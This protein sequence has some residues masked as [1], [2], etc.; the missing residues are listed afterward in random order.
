MGNFWFNVFTG[1]VCLFFFFFLLF[2]RFQSRWDAHV[3]LKS[4][5]TLSSLSLFHSFTLSSL[6]AGDEL[7]VEII[8]MLTTMPI[9]I[10]MAKLAPKGIEACVYSFVRVWLACFF[11]CF[12]FFFLICFF[13]FL[14]SLQDW[15][16]LVKHVLG[17]F[18]FSFFFI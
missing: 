14:K 1:W 15:L 3:V 13:F 7:I 2:K 9:L 12:F 4:L 17:S 6:S 11:F 18:F 5:T 8:G 16:L 10:V